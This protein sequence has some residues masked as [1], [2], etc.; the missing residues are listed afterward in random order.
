LKRFGVKATFLIVGKK[1]AARK[2][3]VYRIQEEGHLI[4]NHTYSHLSH[5]SFEGVF[6]RRR[7]MEEIEQGEAVLNAILG[8]RPTLFR[9][10]QGFKNHLIPEA[11]REKGITLVGYAHRPPYYANG[12]STSALAEKL[13]RNTE[14]GSIV[15]FHDGWRTG[16]E[17]NCEEMAQAPSKI[18]EGL[19][20]QGYRF[21][22]LDEMVEEGK[23]KG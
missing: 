10:P 18:I 20:A 8:E 3:L 23:G 5:M 15:N 21:V 2:D 1:A 11:C 19:R 17:W 12:H 7:V 6:D 16:T 4:G 9:P 13:L 22:T 14:P